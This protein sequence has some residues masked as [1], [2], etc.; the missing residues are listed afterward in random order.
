LAAYLALAS[1]AEIRTYHDPEQVREILGVDDEHEARLRLDALEACSLI[2]VIERRGARYFHLRMR[3]DGGLHGVE[4]YGPSI[5]EALEFH[6]RITEELTEAAG[7]DD[8]DALRERLFQTRPGLR[9]S[10]EAAHRD[11]RPW[12][13]WLEMHRHAIGHFE[14]KFAGVKRAHAA[15]F[16]D[17]RAQ[18]LRLKL[19]VI[20]RI[21]EEILAE[22]DRVFP[23]R[24][25]GWMAG[26]AEEAFVAL[27]LVRELS[28]K[29][30]VG[31]EQI[32][33][34]T[35]EALQGEGLCI[36]DLDGRGRVRDLLLPTTTGLNPDEEK[37]VFLHGEVT[38]DGIQDYEAT[39]ER[40]AQARRKYV[41]YLIASGS[42]VLADLA[43][44]DR[45]GDPEPM[46]SVIT[47]R[48]CEALDLVRGENEAAGLA[49]EVG[50]EDVRHAYRGMLA[51]G[52]GGALSP[53]V[54]SEE[55][56]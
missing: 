7:A 50:I 31:A 36:V 4:P 17:V 10:Y 21:T 23:A 3:G 24:G 13:L 25:I 32:F 12:R 42:A 6:R 37:S 29:Y 1:A 28:R 41:G 54:S 9:E 18:V 5:R 51:G 38:L 20:E 43:R 48:V 19:E 26:L 40:I 56:R 27:P 34:N 14:E 44:R 46:L 2:E 45:L 55:V 52:P 16:K 15:V 30:R 8:T 35:I 33:L 53:N 49:F 39:I 22:R 11:G 47:E